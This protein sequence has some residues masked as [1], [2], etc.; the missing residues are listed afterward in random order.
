MHLDTRRVHIAGI[1]VN[2]DEIWM[3]QVA[4]NLTMADWGFLQGRRHL[5]IDRDDKFTAAFRAIIRASDVKILR[6]P[7]KSPDMNA[8]A[9]RWVLSVKSE[10]TSRMVFFGENSLRRAL[11]EYL[12]HYHAERNHQ[13]KGN[14]LLF[15][16]REQPEGEGDVRCRERL[17]GMLKFYYRDAA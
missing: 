10:L 11:R 12:E 8:H 16:Q 1:T 3:K 7:P 9:E 2:P 13:G 4:R 6:L 17:G 15:P 5:I 14:V